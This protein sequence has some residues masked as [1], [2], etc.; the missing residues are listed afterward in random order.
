MFNKKTLTIIKRELKEKLFS[1]NFIIMTLLIPVLMFGVL[2]LQTFLINYNSD[3]SANIRI[4]TESSDLTA[5]LITELQQKNFVKNKSYNISCETINKNDFA[6]Y[7]KAHKKEL[8]AEKLTGLIFISDSAKATKKIG[9]YS[10]NPNDNAVFNKLKSPI[11]KVLIAQY[12]EGKQLSEK[13]IAY[14]KESVDF[15]AFRV[16]SGDKVEK[17]GYGNRIVS[18]LFTF[19]LYMSM[20]FAGTMMMRSVIQEKTNRIVEILLSSINAKDLMTGKILGAAI[21]SFFQMAIWISPLIILLSTSIFML[22]PEFVMQIDMI[23]ILYF[24]LNFAIGSITFLGLFGA[25]GAIFDNEQDAQS[26]IGPVMVLIIIPFFIAI[27]MQDKA[28]NQISTISSMLPFA[29]I[30][31]MPARMTLFAVPLWEVLTSIVVNAATMFAMFAISG[32]IYR[33]GILQTG[34]KPKWSEVVKWLRYDN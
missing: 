20:I 10:K 16:T 32:K 18:F 19:L 6:N 11:N 2:G 8:E 28:D 23:Q 21:T 15:N 33:I 9:Y 29:S 30:I 13:D 22:P 3:K 25:V 4:V 27:G 12:F 24:M 1:K 14:A 7:L 17:E 34:K 5:N 26:G 31:V